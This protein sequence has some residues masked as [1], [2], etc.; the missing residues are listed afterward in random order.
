[1]RI[2]GELPQALLRAH[3]QHRSQARGIAHPTAIAVL[4]VHRDAELGMLVQEQGRGIDHGK[5]A[6]DIFALAPFDLDMPVGVGPVTRRGQQERQWRPRRAAR[7]THHEWHIVLMAIL[8]EMGAIQAARQLLRHGEGKIGLPAAVIEIVIVKVYSTVMGRVMHPVILAA[9]PGVALH[10]PR[11]QIDGAAVPT[12]RRDI[13]HMRGGNAAAEIPVSDHGVIEERWRGLLQE[14][15]ALRRSENTA[16]DHW[17]FELTVV[18]TASDHTTRMRPVTDPDI[19]RRHA[20]GCACRWLHGELRLAFWL[21][22]RRGHSAQE[23]A[24]QPTPRPRPCQN[25]RRRDTSGARAAV[26]A[27]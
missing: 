20:K 26:P 5:I 12:V 6:D 23:V 14:G 1:M 9:V 2:G 3:V 10:G 27:C 7:R 13:H 22:Y 16:G 21:W 17:L 8:R 24:G 11:W 18:K 19:P 4:V 25:L 15:S